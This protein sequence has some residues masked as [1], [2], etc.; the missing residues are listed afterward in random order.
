[1]AKGSR[2]AQEKNRRP[3]KAAQADQPGRADP[4]DQRQHA[5]AGD[6]PQRVD[7]IA[8][9]DGRRQM[10]PQVAGRDEQVRQHHGNRQENGA[11]NRRQTEPPDGARRPERRR[12]HGSGGG[13]QRGNGRIGGHEATSAV[14]R[15]RPP[16]ALLQMICSRNVPQV[17]APVS[18]YRRQPLADRRLPPLPP[19]SLRPPAYESPPCRGTPRW[20][21]ACRAGRRP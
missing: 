10:G 8:G 21:A 15:Y 14:R 5:D 20:P 6:Q 12:A 9:Q 16:L 19:R 1:M 11:E 2:S 17:R 4:A 13:V 7:D 3:G 18:R